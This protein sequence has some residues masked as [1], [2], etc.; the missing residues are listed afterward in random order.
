MESKII[1]LLK[2]ISA[3]PFLKTCP[4]QKIPEEIVAARNE[5]IIDFMFI[6]VDRNESD[7]EPGKGIGKIESQLWICAIIKH[8]IRISTQENN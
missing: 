6:A 4:S 3:L 5:I 7:P 1:D 2:S 8:A